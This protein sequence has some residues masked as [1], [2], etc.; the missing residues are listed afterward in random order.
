MSEQRQPS[1]DG[2]HRRTLVL[3]RVIEFAAAAYMLAFVFWDNWLLPGAW[4]QTLPWRVAGAI[5][6][7]LAGALSFIPSFTNRQAELGALSIWWGLFAMCQVF[8]L[9]PNGFIMGLPGVYMFGFAILVYSTSRR[10]LWANILGFLLWPTL[11]LFQAN[12]EPE[13]WI[14]YAVFLLCG[15]SMLLI[16]GDLLIRRLRKDSHYHA[17]LSHLAFTDGLT[18]VLNRR[19]FFQLLNQQL[20]NRSNPSMALLAIDIDHFK[21][22]NDRHG[23]LTGDV[24]IQTSATIIA[25]QLRPSDVIG[26]TGGE[27][28][29]V[30]L[31]QCSLD[32]AKAVAERIRQAI[33]NTP[34]VL[35]KPSEGEV[36]H[37]TLSIGIAISH[38]DDNSESLMHRADQQL[39]AAKHSGRNCV[40]YAESAHTETLFS[41]T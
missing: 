10:L 34:L 31:P 32:N 41:E 9:L 8:V 1:N 7:V 33:A 35:P 13:V 39:Y 6:F 24:A 27:E 36:L 28:F 29:A 16:L 4:Q 37:L 18:G 14:Q 38:A 25:A 17:K 11:A 40:R 21:S 26:R 2:M 3:F 23:H 20:Q 19:R 15:A 22:I 30:M 12:P 5:G